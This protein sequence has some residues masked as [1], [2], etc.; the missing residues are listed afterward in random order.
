M[1]LQRPKASA[2]AA[3]SKAEWKRGP[4]KPGTSMNDPLGA[5][6][7]EQTAEDDHVRTVAVFISVVALTLVT[8]CV[9][10]AW[11]TVAVDT[12][13]LLPALSTGGFL[14][15][16]GVYAVQMRQVAS[17]HSYTVSLW[18]F[19]L[20]ATLAV[21]LLVLGGWLWHGAT[22]LLASAAL[23]VLPTRHGR[24]T[25]V[26]MT[27]AIAP[28]SVVL[29]LT[30]GQCVHWLC[31]HLVVVGI[32]WSMVCFARFLQTQKWAIQRTERARVSADVHDILGRTIAGIAFQGQLLHKMS[33]GH[34]KLQEEVQNLLSLARGA[35]SEIR[36]AATS[37]WTTSLRE[38]FALAHALL[39]DASIGVV[40]DFQ[41]CALPEDVEQALALTLREAV[42]NILVHS[43]ATEARISL[44]R[45][46]TRVVMRVRNN[47]SAGEP[48]G[49]GMG[50]RGISERCQAFNGEMEAG[51]VAPDGFFVACRMQIA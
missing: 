25:A 27:A 12:D 39:G 14:L 3:G 13:A 10:L 11:N 5:R 15:L 20:Q 8:G 18:L 22:G 51:F 40:A 24:W 49:W 23:V 41:P 19:T 1:A 31:C 37:S 6:G 29:S 21:A 4:M 30:W 38:E 42:T 34:P 26:V 7:T 44:S 36:S 16:A 17:T 45:V 9:V 50:L 47:G 46:G 43:K 32:I 35:R 33:S 28:L 48:V 2:P